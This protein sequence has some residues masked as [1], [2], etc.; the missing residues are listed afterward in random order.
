MNTVSMSCPLMVKVEIDGQP[1]QMELDTGAAYSIM[2]ETAFWEL[3]PE[4]ELETSKVKLKSYSGASIPVIG[5]KEILVHYQDQ[6]AKVAL[7]VVKGAGS[8]LFGRNWLQAIRLDWHAINTVA[9][10][11]LQAVLEK[12]SMVFNSG[13]GTL[14]GFKAKTPM[15]GLSFV[16]PGP[17]LV[18]RPFTREKGLVS[19]VRARA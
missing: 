16:R 1:V 19:S 14:K 8:S 18:P 4:G 7:I 12:Y 6:V 17:S 3:W 13:L 11:G 9:S 15:L 10:E 2:S 5:S